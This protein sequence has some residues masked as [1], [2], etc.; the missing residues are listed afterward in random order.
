MDVSRSVVTDK[1]ILLAMA[2]LGIFGAWIFYQGRDKKKVKV[3]LYHQRSDAFFS[4]FKSGLVQACHDRGYMLDFFFLDSGLGDQLSEIM[5]EEISDMDADAYVCRIPDKAV[6]TALRA[7][8]K[9]YVSAFSDYPG[10]AATYSVDLDMYKLGEGDL[11][12]VDRNDAYAVR[13][14]DNEH[15]LR[16]DAKHML[17]D[18]QANK[19]DVDRIIIASP[20]LVSQNALKHLR[21]MSFKYVLVIPSDAYNNGY[22]CIDRLL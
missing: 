18:V 15:I 8:G 2:M 14:I 5:I 7:T 21:H 4:E 13:T 16:T 9:P 1:S 17:E 10:T 12:V 22:S 20:S 6:D 19:Q 3:M 11:L